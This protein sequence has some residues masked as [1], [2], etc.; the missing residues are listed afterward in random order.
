M[1]EETQLQYPPFDEK[2]GKVICQICGKPYLVISPRHLSAKHNITHPDYVKRYPTAPL[3]C[4]EFSAKTKYGKVK[5]LFAPKPNEDDF[6]EVIVNEQPVRIEDDIDIEKILK[7][8]VYNDPIKQSK[9]QVLDVLRSYFTNIRSNYLIEEYS[10]MSGKLLCHYI[11]D[12]ADPV[13]RIVVQFP[14]TFW[15]NKDVQIDPLKNKKLTDLG[16]KVLVINSKSPTGQEI[17]KVVGAM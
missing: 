8:K 2:T 16:W 6:E 14:R 3:S 12:F 9:A 7:T 5:D 11:T 10:Q 1:S 17:Q 13:L 4:K 15:H